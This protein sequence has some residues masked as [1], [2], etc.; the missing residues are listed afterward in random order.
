M[1]SYRES[2]SE[3]KAYCLE[4]WKQAFLV[5]LPNSNPPLSVMTFSNRLGNYTPKMYF[6]NQEMRKSVENDEHFAKL[7][8]NDLETR[9]SSLRG[10]CGV[11][12]TSPGVGVVQ[13]F[14]S[15][16]FYS[17]AIEDYLIAVCQEMFFG[18]RTTEGNIVF[19]SAT[20]QELPEEEKF[21]KA[22]VSFEYEY[23]TH[24]LG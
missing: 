9:T 15:K 23:E 6:H 3:I 5:G 22:N 12:Y 16:S 19:R 21:F 1:I 20:V 4:K 13:L 11:K 2:R 8:L 7:T 17:S 10:D 14:F 24:V 18:Q